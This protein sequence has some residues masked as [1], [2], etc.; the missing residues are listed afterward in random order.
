MNRRTFLSTVV[1]GV[2]IADRY[3]SGESRSREHEND[4]DSA[5]DGGE[6]HKTAKPM[7]PS[8]RRL[9]RMHLETVEPRPA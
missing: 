7:L 9:E 8:K 4:D 6:P 2:N 3:L 1:G 5:G